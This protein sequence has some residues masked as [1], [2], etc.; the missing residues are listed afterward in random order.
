MTEPVAPRHLETPPRAPA[1]AA[2]TALVGAALRSHRQVAVVLGGLAVLFVAGWAGLLLAGARPVGWGQLAMVV[3]FTVAVVMVIEAWRRL[4]VVRIV[5]SL[6]ADGEGWHHADA[7]WIGRRGVRGRR[8]MVLSDD[9]ALCLWVRDAGRATERTIEARGR[10]LLLRPTV[11]GRSAVLVDQRAEVLL[12]R[13]STS[14]G[15]PGG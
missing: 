15:T 13:L 6:L 3:T 1:H 7:H 4:H 12:A 14:T 2:H 10:V 8:L 5:R 11:E 9:G